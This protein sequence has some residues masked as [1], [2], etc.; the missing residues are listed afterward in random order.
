MHF[1]IDGYRQKDRMTKDRKT[2]G[3]KDKK[4][5][6]EVQKTRVICRGA[7]LQKKYRQNYYFI[8]SGPEHTETSSHV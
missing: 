6:K 2:Q 7:L 1:K 4:T 5:K 3:Q 8:F